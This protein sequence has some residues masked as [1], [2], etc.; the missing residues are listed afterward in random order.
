MDY[1]PDISAAESGLDAFIQWDKDFIGKAAAETERGNGPARRLVTLTIE[2]DD[3]DVCND[4]AIL[5]G[6]EA[7]GYVSS[8]GYA[9][10]VGRSMALGYVPTELAADGQALEVEI[11]GR[12]YPAAIQ[13]QPLYDPAGARMR[14]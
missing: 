3:I 8:G 5:H 4:E 7:L 14:A 1:R 11:N 10:H 9:H 6:G 12:L 2:T 13:G